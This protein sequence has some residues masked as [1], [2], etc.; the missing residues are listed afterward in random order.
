MRPRGNCPRSR[1]PAQFVLGI[2]RFDRRDFGP[3]IAMQP[4]PQMF[5]SPK[6]LPCLPTGFS[7]VQKLTE[8]QLRLFGT[9]YG[10]YVP[11]LLSSTGEA[12]AATFFGSLQKQST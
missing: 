1:T 4:L 6:I 2:A 9:C 3:A 10:T 8:V 11:W 12:Q 7:S 5:V